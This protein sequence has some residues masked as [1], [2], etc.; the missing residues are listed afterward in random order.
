MDGN[1]QNCSSHYLDEGSSSIKLKSPSQPAL[2]PPV[3]SE[4]IVIAKREASLK[5][6]T[7]RYESPPKI[8]NV[9]QEIPALMALPEERKSQEQPNN[10][11]ELLFEEHMKENI[12]Y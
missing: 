8:E 12:D 10:Q 11:E 6:K 1:R 7:E 2:F 9:K 4:A 5:R 3:I